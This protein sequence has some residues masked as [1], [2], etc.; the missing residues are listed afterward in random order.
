[1]K[2]L[3]IRGKFY[4]ILL[5]L[6]YPF[7]LLLSAEQWYSL[8]GPSGADI[9]SF[10]ISTTNNDIVFAT[11]FHAGVLASTDG[12]LYWSFAHDD[13]GIAGGNPGFLTITIDQ[14]E[15]EKVYTGNSDGLFKTLNSGTSW[16]CILNGVIPWKI[17]INPQ[18]HDHIIIATT[19]GIFY[20]TDEGINWSYVLSGYFYTVLFNPIHPD[21][22]IAYN[23]NTGVHRSIDGGLNWS[24]IS[25]DLP[26]GNY[27]L[28]DI[29]PITP[30]LLY[31]VSYN[32]SGTSA[33]Y[34]SI[35][36]GENW[37]MKLSMEEYLTGISVDKQ[38][39]ENIWVSAQKEKLNLG[40]SVWKSTDYGENWLEIV[41]PTSD[42]HNVQ[43]ARTVK[44]DPAN[45]NNIFVG[46]PWVGIFKSTDGGVTWSIPFIPAAQT[47]YFVHYDSVT[48]YIYTSTMGGNLVRITPGENDWVILTDS[49]QSR[50][51]A[52]AINPTNHQE[53][54]IGST[55]GGGVF[56]STNGG[57]SWSITSLY[58]CYVDDIVISPSSP[59]VLVAG[60]S[61]TTS[62]YGVWISTNSGLTWA[63]KLEGQFYTV[64]IHP[65]SADTIFAANTA[66]MGGN[67]YIYRTENGG[68]TWE[69]VFIDGSGGPGCC[70]ITIDNINPNIIYA[71]AN[72]Y[73][74][75]R[76]TDGGDN[77]QTNLGG[78]LGTGTIRD[79][80]IDPQTED[81]YISLTEN[82]YTGKVYKSTDYGNTWS[83]MSND[84][85]WSVNTA[86]WCISASRKNDRLMLI[87]GT[88]G[89]GLYSWDQI[90]GAGIFENEISN[91]HNLKLSLTIY[92]N[93][94]REKVYINLSS[95][96]DINIFSF[97]IQIY[98]ISGRLI[99][100]LSTDNFS[101][102]SSITWDGKDINGEEVDAG[103]YFIKASN[104][105]TNINIIS[106]KVTLI[107]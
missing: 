45:G 92:P 24:L 107:R 18:N 47:Q 99:R 19:T 83:Q 95:E 65:L 27:T 20:S 63:R 80:A 53:M 38:N 35:N 42:Y 79:I 87:V 49:V 10:D 84:G 104:S 85:R 12:G 105:I 69:T 91:F 73:G 17:A 46:I 64:S 70:N 30:S 34:K 89:C 22:V 97:T 44:V 5:L 58:N 66:A 90:P 16:N 67:T 50:V 68:N 54:Y 43:Y 75:I 9:R 39:P 15:N 59:N 60:V 103:V 37:L 102:L 28:I 106:E 21:T 96:V 71:W 3:I 62:V 100:N 48:N 7:T 77:W 74:F 94:F 86:A 88:R 51:S 25:T 32:T 93:P 33:V 81:V 52:L 61:N 13:L 72:N 76:S 11:D 56:K 8:N 26:L 36:G 2:S 14:T 57:T 101:T 1:M 4:L 55:W 29:D 41:I 23:K 40:A 98:D 31:A 6:I 82:F 78:F